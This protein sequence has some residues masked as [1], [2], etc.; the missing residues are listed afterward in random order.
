MA[1]TAAM[2]GLVP[3]LG[4]LLL[5]GGC[6]TLESDGYWGPSYPVYPRSV[7]VEDYRY[8]N[9][10]GMLVVYDS[11][12]R[13]YSVVSSP[14]L[15]WHDGYYYRK[16]R[17]QWE[18]SHHHRGPWAYHRHEPPRVR[19]RHDRPPRGLVPIAVH[20]RRPDRGPVYRAPYREPDDRRR[21]DRDGERFVRRPPEQRQDPRRG[22]GP[23]RRQIERMPVPQPIPWIGGP[24]GVESE[25]RPQPGPVGPARVPP[26]VRRG[27]LNPQP[28]PVVPF[29]ARNRPPPPGGPAPTP[30]VH[31]AEENG[32]NPPRSLG[33]R[34]DGIPSREVGRPSGDVPSSAPRGG[35][36]AERGD[37]PGSGDQRVAPTAA[38]RGGRQHPRG[39]QGNPPGA[40][41]R[42]RL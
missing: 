33:R 32:R 25:A 37:R 23:D 30:R 20:D 9:P 27:G 16:H 21:P 5:L 42:V 7:Y 14:G 12:P 3:V 39:P 17:G 38:V 18:R 35:R 6:A 31:R 8:R 11:G 15:Y 36:S 29:P 13:L 2:V 28:V 24:V 10:D 4:G 26:V 19:G 34:P 41:L 1:R 40:D 22:P